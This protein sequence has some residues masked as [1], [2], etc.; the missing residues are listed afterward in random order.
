MPKPISYGRN[1]QLPYC[2]KQWLDDPRIHTIHG[3]LTAF[4]FACGYTER[5]D[6]YPMHTQVYMQHN[7]YHIR[8]NRYG[9]TDKGHFSKWD[10]AQTLTGARKVF[11]RHIRY[12]HRKSKKEVAN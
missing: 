11:A 1:I 5:I 7:V 4:A 8:T 2:E 3:R 6:T 12:Y 9:D 10:T